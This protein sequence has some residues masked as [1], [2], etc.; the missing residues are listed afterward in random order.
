M[1]YLQVLPGIWEVDTAEA[2]DIVQEKG[3]NLVIWRLQKP[4]KAKFVNGENG[5]YTEER[6][7]FSSMQLQEFQR[8]LELYKDRLEIIRKIF[9]PLFC[10]FYEDYKGR[11]CFI[12]VRNVGKVPINEDSPS[13]FHVIRNPFDLE[14]WDGNRPILFNVQTE[15]GNDIPL[16]TTITSLR[17]KG[18]KAV[19]VNCGILSHPA[20]LLRESGIQVQQSY[21]LYEK[22]MISR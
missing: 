9:N 5:F 8:K 3:G 11:L 21:L 20:I 6:E 22:Q 12:N 2:P 10:H 13:T 18:V 7:P 17:D 14:K 4:R 15:R 19:F 1:L 16:I